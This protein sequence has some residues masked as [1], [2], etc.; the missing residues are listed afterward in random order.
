MDSLE[1]IIKNPYG[2][3]QI[4]NW[5]IAKIM[6]THH[7]IPM[8]AAAWIFVFMLDRAE[9]SKNNGWIDDNNNV[10]IYYPYSE[11]RKMLNCGNTTCWK[12]FRMLKKSGLISIKQ[13][14]FGLPNRIYVHTPDNRYQNITVSVENESS[15]ET[16]EDKLRRKYAA[17]CDYSFNE[18]WQISQI[19]EV[20]SVKM[21]NN[22]DEQRVL[23][24]KTVYAHLVRVQ[25]KKKIENPF[26]YLLAMLNNGKAKNLSPRGKSPEPE[27][28]E[29][30]FDL[31]AIMQYY[32][33]TPL[34]YRMTSK[35]K[36]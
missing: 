26:G 27:R 16:A 1:Q 18:D 5:V 11:M 24:L 2:F 12:I 15:A 36:E 13:Q 10:Y 17:A 23:Y 34:K 3:K 7:R 31:D 22:T 28:D 9:L 33:N 14:G 8:I 20:L 21:P 35:L 25:N 6:E 32:Q 4:P 19:S 30:S 29:P